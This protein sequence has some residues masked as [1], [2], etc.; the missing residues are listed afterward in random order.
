MTGQSAR[1]WCP[2]CR[3]E[4]VCTL[5]GE[6][7][8]CDHYGHTWPY[9][10]TGIVRTFVMTLADMTIKNHRCQEGICCASAVKGSIN[11]HLAED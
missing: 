6:T 8:Q 1:Q 9:D 4:T 2:F 5:T 7:W 3:Y 10:Y 11:L